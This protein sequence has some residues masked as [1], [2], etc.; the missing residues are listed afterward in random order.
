MDKQKAFHCL[1]SAA[2]KYVEKKNNVD[3]REFLKIKKELQDTACLYC[4]SL[5]KERMD[6][7]Y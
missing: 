5:Y 6:D 3:K 4:F 7:E 2:V 1:A